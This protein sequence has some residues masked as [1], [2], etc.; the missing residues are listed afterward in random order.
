[1]LIS[2]LGQ[3]AAS[4]GVAIYREGKLDALKMMPLPALREFLLAIDG[5]KMVAIENVLANNFQYSRNFKGSAKVNM[6]QMLCVGRCQQAQQEL[7][8]ELDHQDIPYVLYKPG[9]INWAASANVLRLFTGWTGKS[10]KDTRAAA[11]FGWK[12]VNDQKLTA[13]LRG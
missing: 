13:R 1:V 6:K 5:E 3:D 10:N 8:R 7:I 12:L 9:G 2:G 4:H 11:Y